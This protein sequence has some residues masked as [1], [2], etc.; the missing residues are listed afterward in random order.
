MDMEVSLEDLYIGRFIEVYTVY[1]WS[2]ICMYNIMYM[3]MYV[4]VYSLSDVY[5]ITGLFNLHTVI[6]YT[7]CAPT[8]PP[9]THT[10]THTTHPHTHTHSLPATNQ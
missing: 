7:H 4:Y 8:Q 1:V 5:I 2:C 6:Y 3:Y 9:P 10:H